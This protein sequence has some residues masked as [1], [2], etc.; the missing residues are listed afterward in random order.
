MCA[1]ACACAHVR[2]CVRERERFIL[3]EL[4]VCVR[5]NCHFIY[6]IDSVVFNL[7]ARL[8]ACVFVKK[9]GCVCVR[10]RES[11]IYIM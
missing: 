3:C 1:R 7:Y 6:V 5:E 8:C 2:V 9:A 11:D 4:I 10:E